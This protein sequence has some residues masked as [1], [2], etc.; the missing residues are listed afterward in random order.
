MNQGRGA[1][2]EKQ[3]AGFGSLES[4][5]QGLGRQRFAEPD[6]IGAQVTVAVGAARR[7]LAG[8]RPGLGDSA[9]APAYGRLGTSLDDLA[10]S[11]DALC[12][13]P[14]DAALDAARSAWR[15]AIGSW[16]ATRAGGVGP[17][18]EA[19]LMSDVAF[20][21]RARASRTSWPATTR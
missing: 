13:T 9:I 17:A 21:A 3:V 11:V 8:F 1:Y 12:T 7:R 15:E 16:Q 19:R 2:R 6:D 18:M 14:S 10:A 4:A 20:A 5:V